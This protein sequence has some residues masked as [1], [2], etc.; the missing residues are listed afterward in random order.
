MPFVD[1]G[2]FR[3]NARSYSKLAVTLRRP[4]TKDTTVSLVADASGAR[5]EVR[6]TAHD[7]A[8]RKSLLLAGVVNG[9]DTYRMTA[10]GDVSNVMDITLAL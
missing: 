8:T 6:F 9:V 7:P 5:A 3:L 10:T 2:E 1:G 4:A